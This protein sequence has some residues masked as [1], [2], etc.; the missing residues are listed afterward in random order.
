MRRWIALLLA[1]VLVCGCLAG[2]GN[3]TPA[4]TQQTTD[5]TEAAEKNPLAGDYLKAEQVYNLPVATADM[6]KEELRQ[7][8]VDYF[9]LQISFLWNSNMDI[10]FPM[11]YKTG[12][13]VIPK[14]NLY[15]G[16]LYQ[17]TGTGSLYRALEY[18]DE[19]QG[20]FDLEKAFAE[21]G[22]YGEG[23]AITDEGTNKLGERYFKYRCM[24][25]FGNQC[26][27]GAWW[28]FGRV[29][30]SANYDWTYDMTVYNGFIPVGCYTYGFEHEGKQYG[31]GDIIAFGETDTEELY[32]GNP[33]GY[34]TKHVI[35]DWNAANG[36]EAMFECYAQL[37]PGD[38][39]V[40]NGHTLMAESVNL[41]VGK[42]G[43]VNYNLSTVNVVE[44]IEG[45]GIDTF[46]DGRKYQQQGSNGSYL[47]TQLQEEKY[48]PF[49]FIELLDENDPQDKK[50]I[51]YYN[52]Y[53]SEKSAVAEQYQ[54]FTF[55]EEELK[56][57]TGP[58]VEKAVTFTTLEEGAESVT[59][60]EFAAMTVGS[61]YSISD[62]FVRV[63]DGEG[64][65][66]L[67]N[68]FR[69]MTPRTREV[70][71]TELSSTW[72]ADMTEGVQSFADGNHTLEIT[73]QLSTGELLTAFSGKLNP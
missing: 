56:E 69:A 65:E 73:M 41:Y 33:I 2:C 52:E 9:K 8:C 21:N 71:M 7:L 23:A 43:E 54:V 63:K 68:I 60:A 11:T 64:K 61:N 34:D 20:L 37:K 26:S 35:K 32:Y 57:M 40:N 6:T 31:P 38:V 42:N 47:F 19:E 58:G 70:S 16:L 39:L 36:K 14:E 12:T 3:E 53:F 25:T 18:Y 46:V 51:D 62:V 49:T 45:W 17:S 28:G 4:Q 44:Q 13:K 55:T 1:A 50:H 67:K 72:E 15:G 30:N 10:E 48:I 22:G 66:V 24:M 59:F 29:I 27:V 5:A